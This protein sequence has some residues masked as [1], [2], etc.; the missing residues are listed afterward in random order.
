MTRTTTQTTGTTSIEEALMSAD[1]QATLVSS[2][3]SVPGFWLVLSILGN[4]AFGIGLLGLLLWWL[5]WR[6]GKALREAASQ[7][8][9][10]PATA[11]H[12]SGASAKAPREVSSLATESTASTEA[13][14][15]DLLQVRGYTTATRTTRT[16][17]LGTRC[18]RS[19]SSNYEWNE[20]LKALVAS[21]RSGVLP[22]DSIDV[23][24][25]RTAGGDLPL[26]HIGCARTFAPARAED[27]YSVYG[28]NAWN[29]CF[30]K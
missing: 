22:H 18:T 26:T 11:S 25:D 28:L 24:S 1:E 10:A 29:S 14:F 30:G 27:S 16:A 5:W 21:S 20:R 6:R 13:G 17:S 15:A 19:P 2:G 3:F 9:L 23:E 12:P 7:T 8:E 4:I